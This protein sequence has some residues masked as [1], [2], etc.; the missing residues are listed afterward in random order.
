MTGKK[1]DTRTPG[2]EMAGALALWLTG[3]E[4]LHYGL[5]TGLK[6][7]ASN[8]G[9]AQEAYSQKLLAM[10]PQRAGLHILDIGGGAGETAKRLIEMGHSV[11]IVVPSAYLAE[12]CRENAKGAVV[13]EALFQ[14]AKLASSFDVCLFSESF[15]YMP[16]QVSLPKAK[17]LLSKDGVI[18]IGDTFRPA[19]FIRGAGE[20]PVGGGHPVAEFRN[21]LAKI[22]LRIETE[23]N[24]TDA[25]APSIELE[26]AFFN[27]IGV[28][29]AGLDRE[30]TQKRP[31]LRKL[32][33][34]AINAMMGKRGRDK[35]V[36]RLRG[37]ERTADAFRANNLYLLMRLRQI[38]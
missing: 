37:K 14:D 2:L 15:Q 16:F 36:Q 13:H 34:G 30:L 33:V 20:R 3:K 32:L 5:W 23:E 17:K 25:V 1:I 10:L 26:Q 27:V 31:I 11:E 18:V 22:G 35:L 12:R 9:L 6:V 28:G 8:L 24:V 4:H 19:G 21:Y 7:Q 29:M 38:T